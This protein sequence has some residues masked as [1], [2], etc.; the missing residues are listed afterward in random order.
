M[1]AP[2]VRKRVAAHRAELRKRGL[3][4]A[5]VKEGI[6][7]DREQ[8]GPQIAAGTQAATV[9]VPAQERLLHQVVG[10]GLVARQRQ[11]VTAQRGQLVHQRV[12]IISHPD[13]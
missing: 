5:A 7:Q 9:L 13:L 8:P 3:R 4:P 1:P 10:L 12:K 11:R 2:D 6:A